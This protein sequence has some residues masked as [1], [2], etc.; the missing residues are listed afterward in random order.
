MTKP[1]NGNNIDSYGNTYRQPFPPKYFQTNEKS[2]DR[3][4]LSEDKAE[5]HIKINFSI[6]FTQFYNYMSKSRKLTEDVKIE[7]KYEFNN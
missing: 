4:K 1:S 3:W 5:L 2:M 7:K 6:K